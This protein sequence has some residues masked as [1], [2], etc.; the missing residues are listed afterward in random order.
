[1]TSSSGVSAGYTSVADP[2][3]GPAVS[4]RSTSQ[5]TPG[6]LVRKVERERTSD[7]TDALDPFSY[8][9]LTDTVAVNGK[10]TQSVYTKET[11]VLEVTSPEGR[12]SSTE[13]DAY[14]RPTSVQIGSLAPT[15]FDYYAD[16]RLKSTTQLGRTS[17]QVFTG[18]YLTRTID[19]NHQE[20]TIAPD[21]L[22]RPLSTTTA[23]DSASFA[24]DRNSNV[25]SVTP[26]GQPAHGSTYTRSTCSKPTPRHQS[27]PIP[28][29]S[30][31]T[32]TTTTARSH[33]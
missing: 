22:G 2:R 6:G 17:T 32:T 7:L 33:E 3:F 4:V 9:T 24:W 27:A 26:P 28:P 15:T 13:L 14:G 25:T 10:V 30:R 8:T 18:A 19:P 20:T 16:G 31:S 23:G 5:R 11:A 29:L 1:M 21:A 12:K